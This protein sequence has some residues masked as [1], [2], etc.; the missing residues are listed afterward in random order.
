M[1]DPRRLANLQEQQNQNN[2]RRSGKSG[3]RL[4]DDNENNVGNATTLSPEILPAGLDFTANKQA[5]PPRILNLTAE[6]KTGQSVTIVITA[7]RQLNQLG[8]AGPVT[9]IVEFGN[10]TQNTRIE[11][12]VPI[13]PYTGNIFAVT[14]G[15][16]PEDSGAVIQVPTGIVR[17]YARYD[18]AYITPQLQGYAFGGP[19]S[20]SFPL[21]PGFGPFG[22]T[23]PTIIFG[24]PIPPAPLFIKAFANYFGRHHSKLYKTL[25]LYTGDRAGINQALFNDGGTP[26]I[27]SIPPFA[28][29]IQVVRAPN[30]SAMTLQLSDQ[31]IFEK[32]S[33]PSGPSPIIPITGNQNT[34][35]LESASPADTVSHVKVV[36][37]IGF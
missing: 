26:C 15:T 7:A 19:G 4:L 31:I 14:P 21:G 23:F 28:K 18:D 36:F 2:A 33:I 17:A 37:E 10:G 32:Y 16:Q 8:S 35:T 5:S 24:A 30:T 13:G 27:Y 22:P 11:F 1:I 9:G 34:F 25:Y 3:M 12:D 6:S 20:G 29:T